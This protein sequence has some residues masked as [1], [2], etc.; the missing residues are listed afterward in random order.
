MASLLKRKDS[1]K[2]VI[3]RTKK[4]SPI[5]ESQA[6][7]KKTVCCTGS[8]HPSERRPENKQQQQKYIRTWN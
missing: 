8:S 1:F 6:E 2:R 7:L 4:D 5:A 3:L